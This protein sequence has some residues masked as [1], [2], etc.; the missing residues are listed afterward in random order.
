MAVDHYI[1]WMLLPDC[2]KRKHKD[3]RVYYYVGTICNF[4]GTRPGC[5]SLFPN[6]NDKYAFG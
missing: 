1:D 2:T 5:I 4:G 3:E 6:S